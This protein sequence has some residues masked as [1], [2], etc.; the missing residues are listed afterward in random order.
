MDENQ[1]WLAIW[2]TAA[3]GL[4]L[5]A[6]VIAGCNANQSRVIE[7]MTRQGAHPLDA[8]CAIAPD[9]RACLL[10]HQK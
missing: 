1:F 9:E 10:R 3:A 8:K 6:L 7:E 5:L 2:R 4:C